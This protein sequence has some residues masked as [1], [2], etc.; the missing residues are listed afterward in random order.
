MEIEV[1]LDICYS[2]V[3]T[4]KTPLFKS[5]LG[6]KL[7]GKTEY[8]FGCSSWKGEDESE[9]CS[10]VGSCPSTL[11]FLVKRAWGSKRHKITG[12]VTNSSLVTLL[13]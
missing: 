7:V 4:L 1:T 3:L 2:I 9:F 5:N 12:Q 8:G 6:E 13:I 10:S 11:L